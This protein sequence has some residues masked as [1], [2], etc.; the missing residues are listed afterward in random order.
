M[1]A[2]GILVLLCGAALSACGIW[3]TAGDRPWPKKFVSFGPFRY[4]RNP[5]SLGLTIFMFGLGLYE[6]SGLMVAFAVA[7][8]LFL[9]AIVVLV[10]EPGLEK[11]FGQSYREYKRSVHRWVPKNSGIIT[12]SALSAAEAVDILIRLRRG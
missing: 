7:L 8:F 6:L 10:E 5:M 4:V 3:T 1:I 9:H 12:P 2:G 11:R